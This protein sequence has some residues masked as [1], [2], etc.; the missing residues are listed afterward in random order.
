MTDFDSY[1]QQGEPSQRESAAAW[2]TAIG[3]QSVDGLTPSAYLLETAQQ[4]IEGHIT[5]DEARQR[6]EAY[7]QS[8]EGRALEANESGKEEAD[9]VAGNI[10]KLLGEKTF[11]LTVASL[12]NIHRRLFTGVFRH[13]GEFRTYNISKRE[14]VLDGESV[15]YAPYEIIS[16]SLEYDFEQERK[17]DYVALNPDQQVDRLMHFLAGVWQ[18]H[19][20]AEGNTRA[21]AVFAIFY[22]RKFGYQLHNEPFARYSL[23]FR[24]ALVRANYEDRSRGIRLTYVPLTNFFRYL[25]YGEQQELRNRY[26]H[27]RAGE[28]LEG[29]GGKVQ[30]EGIPKG[31]ICTLNCTLEEREILRL[32]SSDPKMTQ[33]ALASAIGK[34]ER[35]IKTLTSRLVEKGYM[36][37]INGRRDG[38]WRIMVKTF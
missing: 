1:I 4:N 18:I 16:E 25:L 23:F 30:D 19:P 14:W 9:K 38:Y 3:L 28:I 27:V 10:V 11:S 6:I 34:S 31:N 12:A 17:F 7:Y 13:A 20:F 24:N 21:T 33:K 5:V 37:R 2:Q 26:L 32:L 36:V 15:I 29:I 35:T 8:K 22:L